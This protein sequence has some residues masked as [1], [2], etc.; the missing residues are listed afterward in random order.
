MSEAVTGE[1]V[2]P[3]PWEREW[4]LVW[5]RPFLRALAELPDVSSACRASSTS[6]TAAY[7]AR[8]GEGDTGTGMVPG[9][10]EAWD[11]CLLLARDRLER[12]A[13]EFATIGLPVRTRRTVTRTKIDADG[14]VL[15]TATETTE[16]VSAER[17]ATML[18]FMLK[19]NYPDKY[20]WADRVA[21]GG[22][23]EADAPIQIETLTG[24]DRQ[25]AALT[26]ALNQ[27][28]IAAGSPPVP[29]E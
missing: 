29:E 20:R 23:A 14:A 21:V 6:R 11:E 25:I 10:A 18:I 3:Q 26:E 9:F 27:R 8:S 22:G 24:I 19:A 13:F 12:H 7:R 1:V 28:A 16:T 17:S 5:Q 2:N 15:E 4:P